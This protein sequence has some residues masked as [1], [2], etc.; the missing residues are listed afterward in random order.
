MP[1]KNKKRIKEFRRLYRLNNKDK[2]NEARRL[3]YLNNIDIAKEYQL[4]NKDKIKEYQK[5]YKLNNRNLVNA[6]AA[7]RRASR[8]KATPKFANLQKIKDIYL[9]CPKGFHVDHIIPLTS[10]IVC[11]LHVHW[12][13]QYLTAKENIRK[14][15]KLLNY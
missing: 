9:N 12:N 2:I 5:E 7:K 8:L 4:N 13:L 15:N 3:Y 6:H 11:G 1:Y 10:K 14:G